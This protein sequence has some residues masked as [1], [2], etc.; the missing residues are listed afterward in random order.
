VKPSGPAEGVARYEVDAVVAAEQPC[1]ILS[2]RAAQAC[3]QS[4]MDGV[5]RE[6]EGPFAVYPAE[7]RHFSLSVCVECLFLRTPD[8]AQPLSG[9]DQ[10]APKGRPTSTRTPPVIPVP[11]SL[12]ARG[13]MSR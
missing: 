13:L 8:S 12:A 6:T 9:A 4:E 2:L 7:D 1:S 3:V 11:E 5:L 10:R